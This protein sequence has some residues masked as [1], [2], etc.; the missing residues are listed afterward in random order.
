MTPN[1]VGQV[2]PLL[3]KENTM[4]KSHLLPTARLSDAVRLLGLGAPVKG[5]GSNMAWVA[6]KGG[7]PGVCIDVDIRSGMFQATLL[8]EWD[9]ESKMY[10]T[11]DDVYN[12]SISSTSWRVVSAW[13][14]D[15]L[16]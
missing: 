3:R 14:K 11:S 4:N 2:C 8:N 1:P 10:L 9:E 5:R 15:K 16:Q 13:I 6:A 12:D 7:K